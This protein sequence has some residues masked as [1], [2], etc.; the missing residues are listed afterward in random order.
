MIVESGERA[1]ASVSIYRPDESLAFFRKV[2]AY[3]V[4]AAA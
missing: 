3:L 4:I 2:Y 1:E